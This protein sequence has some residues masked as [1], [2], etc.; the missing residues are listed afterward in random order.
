MLQRLR[1]C[2]FAA[3]I[4]LSIVVVS[5]GT[6]RA[7]DW[8]RMSVDS[9]RHPSSAPTTSHTRQPHAV[10][11][12]PG[13][14]VSSNPQQFLIGYIFDGSGKGWWTGN[15]LASITVNRNDPDQSLRFRTLLLIIAGI[16]YS[17]YLPQPGL[18]N[19]TATFERIPVF[20]EDTIRSACSSVLYNRGVPS[21]QAVMS[22]KGLAVSSAGSEQWYTIAEAFPIVTS[23]Q[24]QRVIE[25][26]K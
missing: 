18:S 25:F 17:L 2:V 23:L 6:V 9:M 15:S 12:A 20:Q 5:A 21:Y 7:A 24:C 19:F 22:I 4:L 16:Q 26:A 3:A 1:S 8:G 13:F 11:V 10:N 14:S